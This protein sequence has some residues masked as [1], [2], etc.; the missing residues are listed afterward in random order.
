MAGIQSVSFTSPGYD[1][2]AEQ[3]D[4]DR[5]RKL[6]ELLQAHSQQP[7]AGTE[8]IG[9]VA[10]KKSPMEGLGRVAQG[11]FS[12]LAGQE[13][14]EKAKA[15]SD[16]AQ[17]DYKAMIAKGLRELQG[18]PGGLTPEDAGGNVTRQDAVAPDPIAAMGTFGSHPMGAQLMPLAMQQLQRQQMIQALRGSQTPSAASVGP[19]D[20]PQQGSGGMPPAP[21]GVPQQA[22]GGPA[23]GQ[24]LEMWLQIDPTGKAYIEQLA[25]DYAAKQKP[26]AVPEGGSVWQPGV[27]F[28]GV[29]PKL[30]EGVLPITDNA[31]NVIGV[32]PMPGA[33][34]AAAG[35]AGAVEGARAGFD[36]VTVETPHGPRLMTRAQAAELSGGRSQGL[37]SGD[38]ALRQVMS[39]GGTVEYNPQDFN[40]IPMRPDGPQPIQRYPGIEL[41]GKGPQTIDPNKPIIE[42]VT[43][44]ERQKLMVE[45]PQAEAGATSTIQNV[46]RMMNVAKELH[47]H[48]GLSNITGKVNQYSLLD[49]MPQTR[50]ARGLQD[51]LVNQVGIQALQAM[52]DASKTGGAVG[53]VTEKEWPILQQSIAALSS[54][55]GTA[56]Y[57]KALVNLQDQLKTS[58]DRVKKAYESTY[59]PLKI[60]PVPYTPQDRSVEVKGAIKPFDPDMERRYQEWK[61]RNGG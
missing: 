21:P 1:Y 51:S 59:G 13:A 15:L 16:R 31:G 57:Q 40:K 42:Q 29:R 32:R 60:T 35:Q 8:S 10:V 28:V 47:D 44:A 6:A 55:Q 26:M 33:T 20:T 14:D 11:L 37:P 50:A 38:Q 39:R 12:G 58:M 24:P 2:A 56:E 17:N 25:K 34:Q 61:A 53:N 4:I 52:R 9:G 46:E 23:G 22:M 41:Q 19:Q 18:T 5:R 30:G 7:F 3:A 27:G 43:P 45:K 48:R 36:M 54:A 49:M